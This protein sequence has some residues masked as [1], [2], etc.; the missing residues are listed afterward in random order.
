MQRKR[1]RSAVAK[2][3]PTLSKNLGGVIQRKRNECDQEIKR[4]KRDLA[5]LQSRSR[6]RRDSAPEGPDGP[7][8]N[9]VYVAQIEQKIKS[10]VARKKNVRPSIEQ[11]WAEMVSADNDIREKLASK[12]DAGPGSPPDPAKSPLLCLLYTSPSPRDVEESRMPSSA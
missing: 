6:E 8:E 7:D 10:L 4:L 3:D 9:A 11:Q 2:L 1:R 12:P 5:A